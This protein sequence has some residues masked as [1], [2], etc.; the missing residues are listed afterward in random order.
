MPSQTLT[1]TPVPLPAPPGEHIQH[2]SGRMRA[3]M[4][5]QGLDAIAAFGPRNHYY[6]SGMLHPLLYD[7]VPTGCAIAVLFAN[8][9]DGRGVVEM[10]FMAPG[11]TPMPDLDIRTYSTW[12]FIENPY[13]LEGIQLDPELTSTVSMDKALLQLRRMF[14]DRSGISRVGVDL[15]QM[16][17]GV[18]IRLNELLPHIEFVDASNLF[19]QAQSIKSAWEIEQIV[20]A[21]DITQAATL[22][23]ASTIAEGV[24][25]EDL[26]RAFVQEVWRQPEATGVRFDFITVGQDFSP[27]TQTHRRVGASAGDIVKFDL[28]A[29]VN[30]YGADIARNFVLGEPSA[31]AA[32][33]YAAL[34]SAH[35]VLIAGAVPGRALSDLYTEVMST[36]R[37]A[38]P[39]YNRGHVGHSTGLE[40]EMHPHVCATDP[41]IISPGMVLSLELPYYGYG[42][43][44]F[45]IEDMIVVTETGTRLL[46]TASKELERR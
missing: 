13:N 6:V 1:Y 9:G 29:E 38:L 33:V 17:A 12:T 46:T 35:D 44:A 10:E 41:E 25:V 15:K 26:H 16:H 22:Y 40:V 24:T 11:H 19:A 18:W 14:D 31:F 5:S 45:N 23:A 2:T 21:H 3:L 27:S 4:S 30:G 34:R 37:L 42:V 8:E 43:G 36:A 28:G 39:R 32:D 7:G 20:S